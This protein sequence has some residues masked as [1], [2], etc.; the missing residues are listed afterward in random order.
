MLIQAQPPARGFPEVTTMTEM[1]KATEELRAAQARVLGVTR[2]STKAL[3]A[4]GFRF[5]DFSDP[6]R[7]AIYR[8]IE[9]QAPPEPR[10]L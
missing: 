5:V 7:E 8:E 10:R 6:T 4:G 3:H 9:S 1:E 2:R